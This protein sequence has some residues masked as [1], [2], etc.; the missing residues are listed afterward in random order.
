MLV[1]DIWRR[2]LEHSWDQANLLRRIHRQIGGCRSTEVVD[3]H[4][5]SEFGDHP[6][7]NDFIQFLPAKGASLI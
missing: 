6:C 5:L 1:A 2:M 3:T 7:A 4:R